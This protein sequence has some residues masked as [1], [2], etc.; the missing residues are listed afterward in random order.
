VVRRQGIE[1]IVK[2]HVIIGRD[3]A[4]QSVGLLSGPN[5]LAP[6]AMG[7]IREWHFRQTLLGGQPIET[8][9]DITVVFRLTNPAVRSN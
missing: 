8:E 9:E 6:L 5:L 4:V 7:A 2:L 3:G 1:G